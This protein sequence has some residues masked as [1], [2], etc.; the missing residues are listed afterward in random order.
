MTGSSINSRAPIPKWTGP[1]GE[2]PIVIEEGVLYVR[3]GDTLTEPGGQ[4]RLDFD[5]PEEPEEDD[6]SEE[7]GVIL[8]IGSPLHRRG[9]REASIDEPRRKALALC[10]LG[11]LQEAIAAWRLVLLQGDPV[12]EDH[13][14]LGEW[15]YLAGEPQAAQ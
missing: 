4:L 8:S 11:E 9:Y 13:F 1:L 12:A 3:H 6:N 15:L 5:L 10:E 2:L 7:E 14:T